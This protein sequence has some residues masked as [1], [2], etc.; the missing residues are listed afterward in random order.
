[1]EFDEAPLEVL[2]VPVISVLL[3]SA[4]SIDGV[5]SRPD[6]FILLTAFVLSIF[7]LIIQSGKGVDIKAG[8]EVAEVIEKEEKMSRVKAI[9]LLLV[10]LLAII[11]G[12]ELIVRSSEN[13]ISAMGLTE[14]IFGMTIL[15]LL[16]SI[17]ELARELPAALKGRADITYGNVAGSILAFFLFNAG[18]MALI[19]P[20]IVENDVLRFHI[21][22]C[23][24]TVLYIS[25]CMYR[26]KLD[27]SS[28]IIL[29]IAYIIFFVGSYL[30]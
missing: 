21:P 9:G 20:L 1:M 4:L 18:V 27:R 2:A 25:F 12:S 8:G 7:W 22:I 6:G 29:V 14:T 13:I 26:K 15:A 23:I 16:V 10:S 30:I 17:E 11:V 28:G 5:L 3:I 19:R 24:L